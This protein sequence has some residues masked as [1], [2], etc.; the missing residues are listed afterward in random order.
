MSWFK[1]KSELRLKA[2]TNLPNIAD[3]FPIRPAKECMPNWYKD[4]PLTVEGNGC[5]VR[6]SITNQTV[7]VKGCYGVNTLLQK[8][9]ILSAWED[10]SILVYP[11]GT[12]SVVFARPALNAFTTHPS[13][14]LPTPMQHLSAI[15]IHSPWYMYTEEA[16]PFLYTPAVY[17]DTLGHK[18]FMPSGVLEFKHQHQ[19]HVFLAVEKKSE[20]YE[21][22]IKAGQPLMHLIPLTEKHVSL[23][24]MWDP[25]HNQEGDLNVF[26]IHSYQRLRQTLRKNN[27][28]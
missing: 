4:M 3:L 5:P 9:F 14:Q 1:R 17:H 19:T 2:V 7:T 27:A 22:L 24:C 6:R 8:G 18:H 23:E 12:F 16:T 15:K 10:M 11:N 25:Q 20:P 28:S 21:I 13:I 26:L